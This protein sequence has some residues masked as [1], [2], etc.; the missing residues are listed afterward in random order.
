MTGDEIVE[1]DDGAPRRMNLAGIPVFRALADVLLR[2]LNGD[3]SE[4]TR[5]FE[6]T[7]VVSDRGWRLA[8][9]PKDQD[10]AEAIF[11]LE[12]AGSRFVEEVVIREAGG[13]ATRIRCGDFRTEP[14]V[15]DAAEKVYF[16]Q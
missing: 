1:W 16:A 11:E 5:L 13:D 4:I 8:L 2:A 10:L 9:T 12:I 3:A 6:L 7:P 15:L 14:K